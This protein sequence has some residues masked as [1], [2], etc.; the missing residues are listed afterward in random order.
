MLRWKITPRADS[1]FVVLE[2]EV[3]ETVNFGELR[4]LKGRVILDMAGIRRINSFGVRELLNFLDELKPRCTLEAERCSTAIVSQ[5][6]MLPT[7]TQRVRVRSVMAPLE[8]PKCGEEGESSVDI[9][10][11]SRSVP[12]PARPCAACATTMTL[13]EPEDRYFAF[14]TEKR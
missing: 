10:P 14:L 5:L 3:T 8:C 11:G 9:T 4:S 6:N 13:A 7:F 2:G 1:T 12:I